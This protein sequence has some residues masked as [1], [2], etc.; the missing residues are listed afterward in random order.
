MSKSATPSSGFPLKKLLL[1]AGAVVILFN[2]G[3]ASFFVC[4]PAWVRFGMNVDQCPA[5]R[6]AP[7]AWVETSGLRRGS[8]GTVNVGSA[9]RYTPDQADRA[10]VAEVSPG[11]VQLELVDAEGEVTALAPRKRWSGSYRKSKTAE[12]MLPEGLP[13]GDYTL[14]ATTH[15]RVGD[16]VVEVDLPVYAPARV[17]VLSDRPLYEPGNEM[18]FRAVAVRA[19]DLAPIAGRPGTWVVTDPE[20]T[21]VLEEHVVADDWGVI[22]GSLPLDGQAPTGAWTIAWESGEDRGQTVVTVEPFTL[23]RFQVEAA[24][25]SPWYGAGDRPELAG[26]V[27]YSSG[28]PVADADL[29]L[30]WSSSGTWPMP[31]AWSEGALPAT[32]RTDRSGR[33]S[34]TL[35]DVPSDL[36]GQATLF[37]RIEAIDPAGDMVTGA[38]SVLLSEDPIA[39]QAVTELG[40][41]LVQGFNNRVYLR[42]TTADGRPLRDSE[43]VV[44]RAWDP[45]DPGETVKTDAEG[46]AALQLDPGPPVSVV[47]PAP[48]VRPPPRQ[49]AARI[50]GVVDNLGSNLGDIG[51]G[52]VSLADQ[53]ALDLAATRME[54]CAR[55]VDGDEIVELPLRVEASGRVIPLPRP[56]PVDRCLADALP[57]TLTPDDER[58]LTARIR[59]T[60]QDLPDLSLRTQVW[61]GGAE[62]LASALR[63]QVAAARAC[64]PDDVPSAALPRVL[65][66]TREAGEKRARIRF[67]DGE[68]TAVPASVVRCIEQSFSDPTGQRVADSRE[69]GFAFLS[70]SPAPRL[71]VGRAEPTVVTGYELAVSAVADGEA[72]GATT[73]VL[74]QGTVPPIRLR[75]DPILPAPGEAVTVTL[76]RGPEFV[77]ELPEKLFLRHQSGKTIKAEVDEKDRSARFE[78]KDEQPGWWSV[79]WNGAVARAF[80]RP[81]G[82]LT[83]DVGSD[84]STYAPGD[85]ATVTLQTR[86]GGVG[87]PAAVALVGVDQS[88]GQLVPLPGPE[89][90]SV[91]RDEV[92]TGQPAFGVLDGQALSLGRIQGENAAAA[93]VLRVDAVPEP[94]DTDRYLYV[95]GETD[96]DAVSVI[97]DRF[98]V[99]L[100]ELHGQVRAWEEAA[101]EGEEIDNETMA[102]LWAEARKACEARGEEI[103]D[104][105]GRQLRL[106]WLPDDLLALTDP[107]AVVIDGTHL[108]EDIDPWMPWVREEEPR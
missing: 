56:V 30:T 64:L 107:R 20:G 36:L 55:F 3:V 63:P 92:P 104:A 37:A 61:P 100:A 74:S 62:D 15:G 78:L 39:V 40:D 53:R 14:R 89:T 44:A 24:A 19:A 4:V 48:P 99:V 12:I 101:G 94:A 7:I 51:G 102:K 105:Y 90:L 59:L 28:A 67:I 43:L 54:S 41:G 86:Q 98:Y 2:V 33:F 93:T 22:A 35:P 32:A 38:A 76:L 52:R 103:S 58:L 25:R 21:V 85:T 87:A 69:L 46:V 66:W 68:P 83:V 45:G 60:D 95:S 1:S 57:S 16:A 9:G 97:S 5:G 82:E 31:T 106:H 108:P 96:F 26:K 23:P 29:R 91:L 17:H 6:P 10:W 18:L 73:L 34:M 13:D 42:A 77:G 47:V 50:D 88:L 84:Q 11:K 72:L 8:W 80:V 65:Q 81:Q 75:M 70:A 79:E 49:P 71:S 27:T